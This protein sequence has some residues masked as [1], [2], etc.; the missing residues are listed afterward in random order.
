MTSRTIQAQ[1]SET[2]ASAALLTCWTT[3]RRRRYMEM[4]DV[5]RQ[6]SII[7]YHSRPTTEGPLDVTQSVSHDHARSPCTHSNAQE[8]QRANERGR[9][10]PSHTHSRTDKHTAVP[11]IADPGASAPRLPYNCHELH[12]PQCTTNHRPF[13]SLSRSPHSM[14]Q[15]RNPMPIRRAST[16]T[17][18]DL[19][20]TPSHP[21]PARPRNTAMS[22]AQKTLGRTSPIHPPPCRSP[23][24]TRPRT[25]QTIKHP[26]PTS[27]DI[28]FHPRFQP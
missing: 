7:H 11:H 26:I 14:D 1:H 25:P 17:H 3:H 2:I 4:H 19:T 22:I 6:T 23:Q 5:A 9:G 24:R 27:H 13:H 15:N 10:N 21:P 12:P 8:S 20:H 18:P 16:P 28:Q